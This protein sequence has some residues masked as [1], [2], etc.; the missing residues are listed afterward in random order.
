[1]VVVVIKGTQEKYIRRPL[2]S[3]PL[4]STTDQRAAI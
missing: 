1:M 3:G 2:S 4:Q